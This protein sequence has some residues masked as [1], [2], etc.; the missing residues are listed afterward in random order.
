TLEQT[1]A[2]L[3]R[4]ALA[5]KRRVSPDGAMGVGLWLSASAARRLAQD[6]SLLGEEAAWWAGHGL[7]PYTINGFPYGDFHR[8]IVKHQV[9]RP[10][11]AEPARAEYTRH[12]VAIL[13]RLL[14]HGQP[15]TISTLP[16]CWGTEP[17]RD[18]QLRAAAARLR[19]A[20]R[21]LREFEDRTGRHVRLCLEPE[22]GCALQRAGD[23]V[24]F[25]EEHLLPGSDEAAVRRHLGVCH[26]VCHS[27]VMFEPQAEALGAY[28]RAGVAVGKVQVSA[29]V[30][31]ADPTPEARAQLAAFDEP[32]YLHQTCVRTSP[33]GEPR[34]YEDLGDALR[35]AGGG[36]WRVHFHVPVYLDRFGH[37]ETTQ[38][39]IRECLRALGPEP[40]VH[41]EVETYAW[42]VLPEGLR[43]P[44]LADGIARE[45]EW[46]RA[47][48][49]AAGC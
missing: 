20:A 28:R 5:V 12:L 7:V 13:D 23:V 11:W 10:T 35:S 41:F 38:G 2:N 4:Y 37:L 29:A 33:G 49:A 24:R 48:R 27:A 25:F 18:A 46:F 14:P 26:D 34:F 1:R 6:A 31:M 21:E 16:V 3:E 32:R 44:E 15:A 47:E 19:Q 43:V 9:Y 36:E 39:E 8:E 42:G 40:G 17:D 30:R 45:L 22:P